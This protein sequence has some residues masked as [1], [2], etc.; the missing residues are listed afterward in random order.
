MTALFQIIHEDAD[1]LVINK[2]ADLVCHPTKGDALSSLISRV[3]LHLAEVAPETG[4]VSP[5]TPSRR[6]GRATTSGRAGAASR[7]IGDF[8]AVFFSSPTQRGAREE[9]PPAVST[10]QPQLINRL[11]RETSGL[12]LVAKHA[13]PALE[14]RRLWERGAVRKEYL[15]IVHGHVTT[16]SGRID[17]PLGRDEHSAVAIKDTVRPDGAPAC[18]KFE[19]VKTFHHAAVCSVAVPAASSRGVP[20]LEATRGGTPLEP[21]G[22]DACA[23]RPFS[24][25]RVRPLT[26]RKHQIR[27]HLA[28]IGHPIIGDKLY[29]GDERCY[30]D[31]VKGRLTD[32]QR[33]ALI[34]SNHAL[35]AESLSFPWRGREWTFQAAPELWFTAFVA[36]ESTAA[37]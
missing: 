30:L 19:V 14:L 33:T 25:L 24:L 11:D 18:T 22:G 12:V 20:P 1:L 7:S 17:A 29:G 31:F 9:T 21:A 8:R 35:H 27:I 13:T 37:R 4:P 3:R 28:H 23:T 6:Q 15:A 34:L 16:P 36:E 32:A 10:V 5:S 26:G 2:P